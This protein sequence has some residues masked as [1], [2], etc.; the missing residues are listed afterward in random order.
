MA[1]RRSEA[2]A[3]LDALGVEDTTSSVGRVMVSFG[4]V[5]ALADNEVVG[6]PAARDDLLQGVAE[7]AKARALLMTPPR[8][9]RGFSP[10]L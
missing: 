4:N 10:G 1:N 5:I 2:I 7:R 8:R 3:L 9:L 6:L